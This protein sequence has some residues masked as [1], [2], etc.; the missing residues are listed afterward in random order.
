MDRLEYSLILPISRPWAVNELA[1]SIRDMD[2]DFNSTELIIYIDTNDD[3]MVWKVKTA[4]MMF[5]DDFAGYQIIISGKNPLED[6]APV[7]LRR[8]RIIENWNEIKQLLGSTKYT[9]SIED[10]TICPPDT[11]KKLLEVFKKRSKVGYVEGVEVHRGEQNIIGA[12]R[13]T[14]K[15]ARSLEFKDGGIEEIDG[16]G[17]YCFMTLTKLLKKAFIREGG[18]AFGPDVCYV[19]DIKKN[20]YTAFIRWDIQCNH[21]LVDGNILKPNK[22]VKILVYEKVDRNWI[23]K[24]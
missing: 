1:A 16:G 11:F 22:S 5:I 4:F 6:S 10:D 7:G 2:L 19:M 17:F 13:I 23:K 14:S 24:N 3:A 18:P 12:W 21:W 15:I 9:L 20:G 8:M